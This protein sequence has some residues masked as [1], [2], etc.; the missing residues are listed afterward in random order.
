MDFD[1]SPH[2]LFCE[3]ACSQ[4]A[5][6]IWVATVVAGLAAWTSRHIGVAS[7]SE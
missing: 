7:E 5:A 6:G 3:D 1:A 2:P 4:I